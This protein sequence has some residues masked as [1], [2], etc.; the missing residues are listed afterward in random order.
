[1]GWKGTLRSVNA[2]VNKIERESKKREREL[3]K[4]R[5]NLQKMEELEQASFEVE[6]YENYIDNIKSL[7]KEFSQK[8][9]WEELIN[10]EKPSKPKF[11]EEKIKSLTYEVENYKGTFFQRLFNTVEKNKQKLERNILQLKKEEELKYK[12]ELKDY[13]LLL[14]KIEKDKKDAEKVIKHD[15]TTISNL[16]N[17]INPF[18]EIDKLGTKIKFFFSN[19]ILNVDLNVHSTNIIPSETKSLLKSGKLSTKKMTKGNYNE[20]YQ[21]YVSSAVLRV[22]REIFNL[23]PLNEIIVTAKDELL[24]S[25][26]GH[27]ELEPILS[28]Y[29]VRNTFENLNLNNIDPSDSMENFIHNMNFK[30]TIGFL[31]VDKVVID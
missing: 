2:T 8:I 30:K 24:N 18:E 29:I 3:E 15:E 13:D 4:R 23:F 27:K 5:K 17:E 28:V 1:M 25:K 22:A 21:D 10:K 14:L 9:N 7:H 6:E 11:N 20:L 31:S 26:T 16:I 12:E 19:G